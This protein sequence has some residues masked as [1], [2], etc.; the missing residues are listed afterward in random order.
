MQMQPGGRFRCTGCPMRLLLNNAFNTNNNEMLTLP[1]GAEAVRVDV[2]AKTSSDAP[3]G[4]QIDNDA[5]APL[6]RNLLTDRFKMTYHQEERQ[7]TAY[8]L[9]AAKPKLKKADPESR[10]FCRR[11]QAAPG[12][13]PGSQMMTCQ[14]AT[15]AFFADQLLQSYPGLNWPVVDATGIEGGWDFALTFSALPATLLN[16]PRPAG[17]DGVQP[18]VADPSGGYTIF[19]SIEKQLGLKLKAEK[20]PEQVI[21]IDHIETKPT[22]N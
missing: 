12:A 6:L 16:R 2:T 9:V 14:N 17:G 5:L 8:S 10:I 15:M 22:D 3:T 18:D 13:P 1:A 11:G 20:R 4:A 19:E 21:V 7:V